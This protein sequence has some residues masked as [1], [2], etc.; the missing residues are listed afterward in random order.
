MLSLTWYKIEV[1][2]EEQQSKPG[3]EGGPGWGGGNGAETRTPSQQ[4]PGKL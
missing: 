2:D 4:W 1:A 3:T